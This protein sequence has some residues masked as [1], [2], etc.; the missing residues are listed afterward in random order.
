MAV[1]T[2][3]KLMTRMIENGIADNVT[4]IHPSAGA[5]YSTSNIWLAG[6]I[7][8]CSSRNELEEV[9]YLNA[10]RAVAVVSWIRLGH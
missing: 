2:E 4:V 3:T 1:V 5:Q 7:W 9:N 10:N 6:E 8:Y